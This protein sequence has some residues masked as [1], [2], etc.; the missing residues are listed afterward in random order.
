MMLGRNDVPPTY[1]HF[2]RCIYGMME[3]SALLLSS[4]EL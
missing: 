3:S 4:E 2:L 1:T